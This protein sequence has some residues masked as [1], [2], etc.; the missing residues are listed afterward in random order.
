MSSGS[1]TAIA[2]Q[3]A[4]SPPE[5]TT[6]QY[7]VPDSSRSAVRRRFPEPL[8]EQGFMPHLAEHHPAASARLAAAVRGWRAAENLAACPIIAVAGLLNSG[9][10]SLVAA[11]LSDPGRARA[12]RGDA[13]REGTHRFVLW[14]PASWRRGEIWDLLAERLTDCLG[15]APE[16]LSENPAEAHRQYNNRDGQFGALAIPLVAFDEGLD[17]HELGLLD[18]PDIQT[19]S[20]GDRQAAER[21]EFLARAASL[22]SAFMVVSA[23]HA[24]RDQTLSDILQ[25]AR[26]AMPA[27]PQLLAINRVRPRYAPHEVLADVQ[28]LLTEHAL[29]TCLIA[30]DYELDG[31]QRWSPQ[32]SGGKP[33]ATER[34]GEPVPQFYRP[35]ASPDQNPPDRQPTL[36]DQLS[37]VLAGLE[38]SQLLASLR[39]SLAMQLRRATWDGVREIESADL[40]ARRR[41]ADFHARVL[42]IA[43]EFFG[44]RDAGRIVELRLHQ[45]QPIQRQLEQALREAAPWYMRSNLTL[46]RWFGSLQRVSQ[47]VRDVLPVRRIQQQVQEALQSGREGR[48]VSPLVLRETLERYD[49]PALSPAWG[50]PGALDAAGGCVVD[51][52][53]RED[54]TQLEQS[55][56]A[57]V[58]R[59]VWHELPRG[60]KIRGALVAPGVLAAAMVA[61]ILIPIDLGGSAVIVYASIPELLA[62]AGL[63]GGIAAW[64][65]RSLLLSLQHQA[66]AAQLSNFIGI[67]CDCLGAPRPERL[68]LKLPGREVMIL[69]AAHPA[70]R[71]QQPTAWSW[72]RLQESFLSQLTRLVPPPEAG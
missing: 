62:A 65:G 58:A 25:L 49:I 63:A 34:G 8:V 64:N 45:S 12:L 60:Q 2:A 15:G 39:D 50:R 21:R 5:P 67:L 35:H 69:P 43:L 66:A 22:C 19:G 30:Y 53:E 61:A 27:C 54:R 46:Q 40:E 71:T 6:T 33:A 16:L 26:I 17:H 42:D 47:A 18:C 68:E 9:K 48:I 24:L 1:W 57:E 3:L 72:W 70:V 41:T 55:Q 11:L 59:R 56:L 38:R 14:L 37:G 28:P 31:S 23:Y 13:N 51:R 20:V 36:A 10:T 32:D 4:L 29:Q 7:E 52:F 44:R